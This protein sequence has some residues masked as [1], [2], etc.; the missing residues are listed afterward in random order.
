MTVRD[1]FSGF[2]EIAA[3][4]AVVLACAVSA[5]LYNVELGYSDVHY[6]WLADAFLK[7]RLDL[8]PELL[9]ITSVMDTVLRDGK[10]YWPLGPLP[11][12]IFMPAVAAFGRLAL[13]QGLGQ[14]A[15]AGLTFGAAFLLA[16]REAFS[17][18]D[19]LWLAT[20]FCFGS[21]MIGVIDMGMPWHMANLLTVLFMLLA[22]VERRGKDRPLVIGALLSLVVAARLQAIVVVGFFFLVDLLGRG[23]G[24][25]AIRRAMRMAAPVALMLALLGAYNA[26]RFGSPVWTGQSDHYLAPGAVADRRAEGVFDLRRVPENFA[27]YFLAMPEMKDGLPVA[28]PDGLS[29]LLLSPAFLWIFRARRRDPAFIAAAVVTAASL[30][31]YLSYFGTGS[32]QFGP[33]YL[34]DAL[35]LWFPILLGVFRERG[36]AWPQK[37]VIAASAIANVLLFHVFALHH[38]FHFL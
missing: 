26:A 11:A 20:A 35:P 38:V 21:I 31:M 6:V 28:H 1:T 12:V 5:W 14:M 7:G 33:R 36:F 19:S 25:E 9:R 24:R 17:R 8:P 27:W 23:R 32:K 13:L 16:R 22:L 2:A 15:F 37:A 29:V 3:L 30:L 34:T 18:K 10:Y 4:L